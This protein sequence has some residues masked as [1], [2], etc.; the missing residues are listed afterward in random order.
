MLGQSVAK[1]TLR[2]NCLTLPK[3]LPSLFRLACSYLEEASRTPNSLH[4]VYINTSLV[5]KVSPGCP[6]PLSGGLAPHVGTW[7]AASSSAP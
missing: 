2:A 6:L 5:T 7:G 3:A 1:P 4:V